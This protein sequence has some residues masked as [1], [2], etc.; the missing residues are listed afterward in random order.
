MVLSMQNNRSKADSCS[1]FK[2]LDSALSN[3]CYYFSSILYYSITSKVRTQ[4]L[5]AHINSINERMSA[6]ETIG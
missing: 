5:L 2:L 6:F 4:Q 1:C 3:Y